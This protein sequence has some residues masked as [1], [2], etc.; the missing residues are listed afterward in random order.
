MGVAIVVAL[1]VGATH[2]L[3][4]GHGKSLVA[5]AL[6]GRRERAGLA[7]LTVGLTVTA[8]HT[9]SVLVIGLLVAGTATVAPAALYP[10]LGA[11]T[12]IVVLLMGLVL[13]R[14]AVRGESHGHSHDPGHDPGH[15]HDP[16]HHHGHSHDPG[17][18][19]EHSA[20]TTTLTR[21]IEH[22]VTLK[23]VGEPRHRRG[24]LVALGIT[25]GL[26][27]SPSAVVVLLA[28]VA[29]G[30]AWFGVLLVLAFGAGMALTLAGVGFAVLRGQEQIFAWA[31]RGQR[32][33]VVRAMRW[34]PVASA[35]AVTAAGGVLVFNAL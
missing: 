17:H 10:V 32:P 19:H 5:F 23:P 18:D 31:E 22:E 13:L 4:P 16:G 33:S 27:P 24:V 8:T 15:S 12:G 25:G 6:A 29:A 21:P 28:A 35:C 14:N 26:L 3:A 1:A 30:R 20:A 9:A 2:A 34:L 7:A 11:V